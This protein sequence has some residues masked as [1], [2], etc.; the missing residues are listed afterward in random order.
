MNIFKCRILLAQPNGFKLHGPRSLWQATAVLP[1]TTF[2]LYP[3]HPTSLCFRA[4]QFVLP[5]NI[6][7]KSLTGSLAKHTA[8]Q[9]LGG[10]SAVDISACLHEP[11]AR[12]YPLQIRLFA[13]MCWATN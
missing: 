5:Q 11:I 10:V 12:T 13:L 3:H 7:T 2:S 9:R 8:A 4:A 6:G 1:T